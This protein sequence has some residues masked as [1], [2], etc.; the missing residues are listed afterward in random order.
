M[1]SPP[2]IE[3]SPVN[4]PSTVIEVQRASKLLKAGVNEVKK[5]FTD[6]SLSVVHGHRLALF[7]V[8]SYEAKT[9]LDCLSG[10]EL[11]DK[12]TVLHHG[13]VSWPIG[14]NQAFSN[15]LSGYINARFAAEI[16]SAPG[17]MGQDLALIQEITGVDDTIFHEPLA[18]WKGPMRKSL[19]LAVSLA[20]DFDVMTVGKIS[21]WDHRA[22]HPN[23]V[24]IRELFEQRIDGRTMVMAAP[25]QNKLALDY[26]DVGVAIVNGRLAYRGDPEVC[27]EMVKEESQRL[28]NDRR[29][30]INARISRLMD[31][32]DDQDDSD[33]DGNDSGAN[34]SGANDSGGR[35]N[36]PGAFFAST[37]P[38]RFS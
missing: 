22:I 12:G 27:L 6:L 33:S 35:D 14:S 4:A 16:Y 11:P 1:T 36:G 8:N 3:P 2:V 30:R 29:E 38:G 32:D 15:K 26:C 10:V 7:S 9:L 5:A 31:D 19:E 23:S 13:S 17:R 25:G 24:R 37:A 34:D 18:S 28:K 20:F 21:N